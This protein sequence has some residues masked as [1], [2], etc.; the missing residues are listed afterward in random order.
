LDSAGGVSDLINIVT[1]GVPRWGLSH[2][3][4]V[5]EHEG[6]LLLFES[7][8]L[9]PLQCV[10]RGEC[11][12]GTQAHRLDDV[13]KNYK[14]RVW[15]YPLARP[16]YGFESKRLSEFLIRT[17]GVPYDRAGAMRSAGIGLSFVESLIRP[18]DLHTIFCSE[19]LA[20]AYCEV[21]LLLTDDASRWNPNRLARRL[22]SHHVVLKPH[23]LK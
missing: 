1:L 10:I 11:F 4:I 5:A 17:I 2:V 18:E 16:L 23:R 6:E 8:T 12:N 21:G 3:G 9:D 14:G 7:T 13:V 20:K 15:E 22:R 19:W